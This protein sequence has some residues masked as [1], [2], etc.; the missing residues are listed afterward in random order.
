[1]EIL[2]STLMNMMQLLGLGKWPPLCSPETNFMIPN[3]NCQKSVGT[4][5]CARTN[6]A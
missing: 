5:A 4:S 1:M 2:E 6:N 3:A